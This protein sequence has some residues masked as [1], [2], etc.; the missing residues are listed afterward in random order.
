[1]TKTRLS[2]IVLAAVAAIAIA[3]CGGNGGSSSELA[4]FAPPGSLIFVEGNMRPSGEL[5]TNADSVANTIA[6][7]GL[8]DLIVSKLESSAK[9]DGEPLDFAREVEPWLGEKAS[10]AFVK[11]EDG[12]PSDPVLAIE[13]TDAEAAQE[14]I[15]KRAQQSNDPYEDGSYEGIDF[16]VGG[17]EENAIG[18]I[19]EFVVVAEGETGFKDAIDA[20]RGESLA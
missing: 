19:D 17:S 7:E 12:D 4:G 20:S 6:G 14:F 11:L 16:K 15:D 18:L 5:K 9:D 13:T 10:V 8:G 1:M 2:L 3:G